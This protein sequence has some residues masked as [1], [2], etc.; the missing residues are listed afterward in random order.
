MSAKKFYYVM[1]GFLILSL[2]FTGVVVVSGSSLLQKKSGE[3]LS[4]KLDNRLLDEQQKAIK[5]ANKNID[6]YSQLDSLSKAIVPQDKDQA[7]TVREIVLLADESGVKIANIGFPS[8]N[9]GQTAPKPS[10]T[11]NSAT[12]ATPVPAAPTVSQVKPV[13]GIT[14]VYVMEINVQSDTSA[15]ISYSQ[16]ITFLQKL[17]TNRRTAQVSNITINPDVHD[18][19]K[20][21]F[22][23][24]LNVYIKP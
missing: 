3:L 8:S 14:G 4:A 2:G 23:L 22:N 12:P 5:T 21:T 19:N 16:L 7:K 20:I 1:V 9:L 24:V 13:S 10:T 18:R 6:Q 11:D 17:E 15:P